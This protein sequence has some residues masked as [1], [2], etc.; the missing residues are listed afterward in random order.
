MITLVVLDMAG[1]TISDNGVVMDALH[2]AIADAG[3]TVGSP[4]FAGAERIVHET[5]GQSKIEVFRRVFGSEPAA[6][7]A[8]REFEIAYEKAVLAGRVHPIP[9]AET[10]F[11][12]L[13]HRGIHTCLTTGFSPATR[14]LLIQQLGWE[15]ATDLVLSPADAGRGRPFPDLLWSAMLRL[16]AGSVDEVAVVGDTASDMETGL[17]AGIKLRYGVLTG[18]D[19]ASRLRS[20]GATRVLPSVAD[21]LP[22]LCP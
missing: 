10:L 6:E 8:S 22:V 14:D 18:A 19:D 1:T 16:G 21:L 9:G 12:Q 20:G 4:E 7:R 5:M 15:K 3:I 11:E 2:A 13:R 17:R